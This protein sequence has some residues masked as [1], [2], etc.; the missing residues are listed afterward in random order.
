MKQVANILALSIPPPVGFSYCTPPGPSAQGN[1]CGVEWDDLSTAEVTYYALKSWLKLFPEYKQNEMF[2]MGESY[3][4]VYVPMLVQQIL[5]YPEENINLKVYIFRGYQYF[6]S[7][8]YPQ[9]LAVGD[10]CT[11]PDVCG[12]RHGGPFYYIE[13]LYGKSAFSNNL[14]REIHHVCSQEELI[15]GKNMSE[16]C[17][18]SVNKIPDEVGGYWMYGFYDDCWYENDI[19]RTLSEAT[20]GSGSKQS[21][22][23]PP[24]EGGLTRQRLVGV[25][26]DEFDSKFSEIPNGYACGGPSILKQYLALDAVKA[27]LHV[28]LDAVF[29]QCDNGDDFTY[30]TTQPDLISWYKQVIADE[31]LRVLVYNGDADPCITAFQAETWTRS[32]GFKEIQSWR[33]WTTDNCNR[34]GGAVT[35]LFFKYV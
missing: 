26:G 9:G 3:A 5:K 35:R 12:G 34:M 7:L 6:F 32:L 10:A 19:R 18:N 15:S 23:G 4:G 33:P 1:D 16:E 8:A 25:K 14:Y 2:V 29:F 30:D 11:P 22:Y 20:S 13:F 24:I 28:P 21:Y 17:S 31:T 27:A